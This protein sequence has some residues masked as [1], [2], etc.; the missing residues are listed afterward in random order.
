MLR[1]QRVAVATIPSQEDGD[2]G[3][4]RRRPTNPGKVTL[5][6]ECADQ[7]VGQG[8]ARPAGIFARQTMRR[9]SSFL[10]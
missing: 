3:Q 9:G 1:W 5:R 8:D 7:A 10:V 2:P 6:H 4:L